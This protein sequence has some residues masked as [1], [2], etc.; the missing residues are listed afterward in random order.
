MRRRPASASCLQSSASSPRSCEPEMSATADRFKADATPSNMAGVTLMNN[1]VGYVV[2]K[3]M[4][5][6][7]GIT[8][9]D[10]PSMIRVDGEHKIDF[11]FAEIAEALGWDD[12]GNDDFDE[13][14]VD[15]GIFQSTYLKE[16]YTK[17]FNAI[18]QNAALVERFPGRLIVNG[19]FDARDG[20]AGL[21]QLEEDHGRYGLQGVKL[22]TAEWRQ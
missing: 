5:G 17:G 1:Q 3:V 13:G 18:E 11:D 19:R 8:V 7:P 9:E 12:F 14:Y 6:K 16:W 22:Y 21:R 2:A 10:L 15:V 4:T 20:E